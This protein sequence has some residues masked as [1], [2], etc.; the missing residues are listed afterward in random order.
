MI[1]ADFYEKANHKT[2]YKIMII[3]VEKTELG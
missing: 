3:C 1:F 2:S